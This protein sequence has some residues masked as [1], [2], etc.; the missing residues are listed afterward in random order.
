MIEFDEIRIDVGCSTG[1]CRESFS[2]IA[3]VTDSQLWL[4]INDEHWDVEVLDRRWNPHRCEI[5]FD[6]LGCIVFFVRSGHSAFPLWMAEGDDALSVASCA[7]RVEL[8][9]FVIGSS[10]NPVHDVVTV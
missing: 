8:D 3:C 10:L 7:G 4:I 9:E 5:G 2:H 1:K 6:E